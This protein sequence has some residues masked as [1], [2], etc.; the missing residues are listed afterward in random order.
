MFS[1]SLGTDLSVSDV[2]CDSSVLARYLVLPD[3]AEETDNMSVANVTYNLC[4]LNASQT[5]DIITVV[6]EE[7]NVEELLDAVKTIFTH[8]TFKPLTQ[9]TGTYCIFVASVRFSLRLLRGWRCRLRR[10]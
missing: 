8:A 5:V 10:G 7:A 9:T 6:V 3:G 1:G 2:L 4:S